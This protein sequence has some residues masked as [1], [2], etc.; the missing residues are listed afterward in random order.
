MGRV[1]CYLKE[2][3]THERLLFTVLYDD[4]E[5]AEETVEIKF[6]FELVLALHKA[7]M[8]ELD[9]CNESEEIPYE[10]LINFIEKHL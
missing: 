10:A 6:F 3:A 7:G 1:E 5:T 4:I 8:G 9:Y 2:S